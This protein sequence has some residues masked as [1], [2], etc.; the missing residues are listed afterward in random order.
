MADISKIKLPSG[1][2]YNLRDR[3]AI[4]E[5]IID[6]SKIALIDDGI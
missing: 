5:S 2:I 6:S 4:R 3:F 1:D